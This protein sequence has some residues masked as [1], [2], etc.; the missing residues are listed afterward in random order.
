LIVCASFL[1]LLSST[2][3]LEILTYMSNSEWVGLARARLRMSQLSTSHV[4]LPES[5]PAMIESI[6]N[7]LSP[8]SFSES[9]CETAQS[10]MRSPTP[11]PNFIA[12]QAN[13]ADAQVS[14]QEEV[15]FIDQVHQLASRQPIPSPDDG[16]VRLLVMNTP[17]FI[18]L[19]STN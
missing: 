6:T 4:S 7:R 14:S 8:F 18:R 12:P 16:A 11:N 15:A 1:Y 2:S 3:A 5:Q 9:R 10:P 17:R 19:I 13:D